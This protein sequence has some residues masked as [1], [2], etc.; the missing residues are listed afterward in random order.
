MALR[1]GEL[2]PILVELT[3]PQREGVPKREVVGLHS[4]NLG[5][6]IYSL[7]T[8]FS[9]GVT[10]YVINVCADT[11]FGNRVMTSD[12]A[13]ALAPLLLGQG[14]INRVTVVQSQVP[15]EYVSPSSIGVDYVLDTFRINWTEASLHLIHRHALPFGIK[16]QGLQPWLQRDVFISEAARDASLDGSVPKHPYVVIGLTSRYRKFDEHYYQDLLRDVPADRVVFVGVEGDMPQKINVPGTYLRFN[17]FR[18]LAEVIAKAALF[19]G[20]ASFPYALAEA[21][22]VPR[23]VELAEG[24]NVCPLE[25]S[26]SALHLMSRGV[27]RER[28]FGS[29]QIPD[30]ELTGVAAR[31]QT[32]LGRLTALEAQLAESESRRNALEANQG[33]FDRE[34][35]AIIAEMSRYVSG[36]QRLNERVRELENTLAQSQARASHYD[37]LVQSRSFLLRKFVRNS[38][39]D[40]APVRWLRE[41]VKGRWFS[42]PS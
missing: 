19:I 3:L 21:L 14:T 33:N 23:L 32:T 40:T 2:F 10:H 13:R 35:Q 27:I 16:V 9:L 20:N 31:L 24:I 36:C 5:D 42:I 1:L 26:A 8:A 38:L 6:I 15:W 18:E 28:I 41:K 11:A 39:P 34:R 7:P 17:D 22:K 4:G 30:P 37:R 12:A 25:P 29:L